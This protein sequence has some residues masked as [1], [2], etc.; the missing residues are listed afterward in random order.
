MYRE[1]AIEITKGKTI[2]G[3]NGMTKTFCKSW[4]HIFHMMENKGGRYLFKCKN[5]PAEFIKDFGIDDYQ[6]DLTLEVLER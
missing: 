5:C 6:S 2:S 4:L 3:G 1:Q